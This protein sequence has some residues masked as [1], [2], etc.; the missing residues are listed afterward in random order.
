MAAGPVRAGARRRWRQWCWIMRA[1][2]SRSTSWP[3][4]AIGCSQNGRNWA[5]RR[6][7]FWSHKIESEKRQA[8]SKGVEVKQRAE[9]ACRCS[10]FSISA[11]AII[12]AS[13]ARARHTRQHV[14]DRGRPPGQVRRTVGGGRV[15]VKGG[16]S[17]RSTPPGRLLACQRSSAGR[18]A[19]LLLP[20]PPPPPCASRRSRLRQTDT[21]LLQ[22]L[23]PS[24][25][26]SGRCLP[27]RRRRRLGPATR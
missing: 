23:Q 12:F 20:P 14:S 6:A 5:C 4:Q 2:T 13:L 1:A 11:P 10:R 27:A 25:G 16:V 15:V 7:R 3:A 17:P 18:P 21:R 19:L 22:N 9:E 8:M 26:D 24:S